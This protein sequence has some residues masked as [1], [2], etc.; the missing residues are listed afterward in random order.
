MAMATAT[1]L[2]CQVAH[3]VLGNASVIEKESKAHLVP[4]VK[5]SVLV[6]CM[7]RAISI[8]HAPSIELPCIGH[9]VRFE[10]Q[11]VFNGQPELFL[12]C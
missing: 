4:Q 3:F 6:T 10:C 12:A 8:T 1:G 5:C 9:F 7:R 2:L 11:V